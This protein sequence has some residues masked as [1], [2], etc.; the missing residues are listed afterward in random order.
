MKKRLGPRVPPIASD[1]KGGQHHRVD[2]PKWLRTGGPSHLSEQA[3]RQ[4]YCL[5]LNM[6]N[7]DSIPPPRVLNAPDNHNNNDPRLQYH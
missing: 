7:L 6:S 2:T 1:E 3:H 4:Q 5:S